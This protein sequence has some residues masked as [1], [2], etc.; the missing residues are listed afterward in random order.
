MNQRISQLIEL[1]QDLTL[2]YVEDH[3]ETRDEIL[4]LFNSFFKTIIVAVDGEEGIERYNSNK[5]DLII[6][7]IN[8]PKMDGL[9]MVE[10]I[11]K[12]NPNIPIIVFSAYEDSKNL[13]RAIELNVDGF[14]PK[15]IDFE[16][17]LETLT[18]IVNNISAQ[19]KLELYRSKLE[20]KVQNQINEISQKDHIIQKHAK[21]AAMGE[22]IDII[23]HQWKQPL[24]LISLRSNFLIE[25]FEGEDSISFE[26]VNECKGKILEQV[27]HLTTTLDEFRGF[28]RPISEVEHINFTELFNS[29][30]I[31]LKDDLLKHK[32]IL[33]KELEEDIDFRGNINEIKHI[34]INLIN[35]ARDAFEENDIKNRTITINA[36]K[37]ENG[38]TIIIKDN[39]GGIP[40][41]ILEN[42][43]EANFTTKEDQG[44][45][46]IGL[47]MCKMI[48]SKHHG[49]INV[50]I[51]GEETEFIL[52][53]PN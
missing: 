41:E 32:I 5:I 37:D 49:N 8:M 38:V 10:N 22:M 26:E 53:L 12:S 28:F 36:S 29:L 40:K 47:Y 46:G 34:F 2:L 27:N 24:T 30:G 35:N 9:T 52:K 4:E 45:T 16:K 21:L 33:N 13:K 6:T 15:P 17:Y 23:A 42:I 43:F 50:N 1:S 19:K 39:A 31:L 44:G 48:A 3:K 20:E 51:N 7:D 14:L 18:K 25:M 11:K